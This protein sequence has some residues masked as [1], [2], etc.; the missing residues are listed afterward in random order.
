MSIDMMKIPAVAVL[1]L[2]SLSPP[3]TQTPDDVTAL[4]REIDA[5]K[6]QQ[7]SMQR[8]LQAIKNVLQALAGPRQPAVAPEEHYI[9]KTIPIG[10]DQ[11]KGSASAKVT[12]VEISDYHCPFCRRQTVTTLPQIMDD[13][14]NAGK[15]RYVFVDYPIAELHPQAFRSHEA[16]NCA[17]DQGKFWQ[18]HDSLFANSPVGDDEHLTAQARGIG[19]DTTKFASC[20][21]AGT[22]AAAIRKSISRVEDLGVGGTPLM[23]VGLTPAPGAP[24]K[25]VKAVYGAKPYSEFKAAIDAVIADAR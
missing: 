5:L 17:A 18:M 12:V 24:L 13:Y 23:L 1:A 25:V 11:T 19:L 14:I 3:Q 10:L 21:A 6:A 8:D 2:L 20:L 16:A 4:R 9:G 7:A 22:H 15:A